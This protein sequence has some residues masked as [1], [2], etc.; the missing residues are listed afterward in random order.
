MNRLRF[1]IHSESEAVRIELGG[2]LTGADVEMVYQAWQKEAWTEPFKH[3]ILDIT[4]VT[5]A[6][7]HGRALLVM[8]DRFGGEIVANS[9]E[10]SA[11]ALPLFAERIKAASRV[12]W[13]GKL[14][15]FLIK[16]RHTE[17][18]FPPQAEVLCSTFIRDRFTPAF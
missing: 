14:M 11:M 4:S 6:D 5:E 9:P 16:G 10:S 12:G 1:S 18:A 17:T 8:I 2:S 3:L 7:K 15:R 13:L